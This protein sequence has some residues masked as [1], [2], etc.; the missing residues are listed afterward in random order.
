MK[1]SYG[2][3]VAIHTGPESCGDAREGGVEAL[4]GETTGQGIEPRKHP[5]LRDADAHGAGRKAT[6]GASRR[7]DA[8]ESRA[9]ADPGTQGSITHGNREVPRLP[10]PIGT[11]RE[12]QGQ[13]PMMKERGKSDRPILPEKSSNKA[14]PAAAERMEGRGL[15]KGNP[16]QQNASRTLRRND[17]LNALERVR[18]AARR[19]KEAKFTA[20][21][22]H[23]YQP[24]ALRA[25]YL[26]LKKEAAPGVDGETWRHYG[27]H[28]ED[29]LQA[30]SHRLKR[31]AY[32][33]KPVRRVYIPKADGR[34]R[35]L[36]VTALEDKIV[37]RASVE[38]MNTIYETDFLGFSYGF[39]PGRNQHKA[40]DAV[41]VGIHRRRVNW[42]L[43]VDI[44]GFFDALSH[45]W[46]LRFLRHRIA[47][48]RVLRLIQKWLNAGVLE[49]G[50][51]I[52]QEEGTP[53]GGSASPLLA[54]VYL[55]YAFDQWAQAWR[56]K[57]A[58]GKMMVVRYADDIVLGFEKKTDAEQ[59]WMELKQRMQKFGL[60]LHPEKTRLLEFGRFAGRDRQRR[61]AGKPDTFNFLGLTHIC[62]RTARGK[63]AVVRQTIRKRLQAKLS[64]VKAELERRRH[65]PIP[66]TGAWLK[67]VLSG[68]FRYYGVPTNAPALRSFRFA[69]GDLWH[70][71]LC[72]R[73]QNGYVSW[74]RM[75]RL[76]NQWF[77]P[78][79]IC[80]PYP[81]CRLHV[82]T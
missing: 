55:H 53:Q 50:K 5:R 21:L 61:G 52:E 38:V 80:H 25:A 24:D 35:P 47:D 15:A 81:S 57:R 71:A 77:P 1:E 36:G 66:D 45:E 4:T 65:D 59:F 67:A 41:Y 6:S 16:S 3:G 76:I 64:A 18:Q 79:R 13:K 37:Q 12:V 73:S 75:R 19:N 2:E 39:R 28:L 49:E 34:Q 68:H 17:A 22:H 54:N 9:V 10:E 70:S 8:L 48:R 33:A 29:N 72:R 43:D 78:A 56:Q 14:A 7:R 51:R 27:E 31:G 82:T 58:Q 74:K 60:E 42:V 20:L 44:R 30:L 32:R 11:H 40:L 26:K 69:V 46:L 63:F 62:G 23:I